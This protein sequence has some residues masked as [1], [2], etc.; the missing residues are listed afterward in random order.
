M[1][2]ISAMKRGALMREGEGSGRGGICFV[3]EKGW[4]GRRRC[5]GAR[6]QGGGGGLLGEGESGCR[7]GPG[8]QGG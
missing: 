2:S 1:A 3:E 7:G 6:A 5:T 8:R 4:M